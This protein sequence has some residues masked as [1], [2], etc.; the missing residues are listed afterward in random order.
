MVRPHLDRDEI[1]HAAGGHEQCGF[2]AE[3]FGGAALERVDGWV[4][5]IDI[6]ADF[7][8]SHGATHG[9]GWARNRVA[10]QIYDVRIRT[11]GLE[12]VFRVG[13]RLR[14]HSGFSQ[15]WIRLTHQ[16]DE[17]LIRNGQA[18]WRQA[19]DGA[20]PFDQTGRL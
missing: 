9:W 19:G 3:D 16:F 20:D 17:G 13:H 2:F 15:L 1:A 11:G 14:G 8:F 18:V 7:G 5:E 10:A 4:F 6:V 12:F